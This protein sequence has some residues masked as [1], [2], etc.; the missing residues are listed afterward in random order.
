MAELMPD[1]LALIYAASGMLWLAA[2]GAFLFEYGPMLVLRR[3]QP[4]GGV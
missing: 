2:F 1:H 3:R 4:A